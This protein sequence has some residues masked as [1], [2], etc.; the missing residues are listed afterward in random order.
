MATAQ[1]GSGTATERR[2]LRD[3]AVLPSILKAYWM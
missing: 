2:V 1:E 3:G